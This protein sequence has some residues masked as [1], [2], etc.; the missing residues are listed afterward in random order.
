MKGVE[1]FIPTWPGKSSTCERIGSADYGPS[2]CSVDST[3]VSF[4]A[5]QAAEGY[6]PQYHTQCWQDLGMRLAVFKDGQVQIELKAHDVHSAGIDQLK[7]LVKCLEWANKR[8]S[9]ATDGYKL[10]VATLPFY[11]MNLCDLLGIKR[12]VQYHGISVMDTYAPVS[13]ALVMICADAQRR[14]ERLQ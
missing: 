5:Q 8:M 14:W 9:L 6:M 11:L 1:V 12:T 2:V 4:R 7:H 3:R 10:T 13:E